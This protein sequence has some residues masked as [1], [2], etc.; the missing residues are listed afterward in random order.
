MRG[1]PP[2]VPVS[3]FKPP[4]NSCEISVDRMNFADQSE[5]A[6][7]AEKNTTRKDPSLRGWYTLTA[8]EVGAA[9]CSVQ[10]SP[11]AEN[12]Y[13]A[14]ILIPVSLSAADN[15][16]D[17]M[18]YARNLAYLADFEPW[19]DWRHEVPAGERKQSSTAPRDRSDLD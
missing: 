1:E 7:L 16:D 10:Y 18:E 19:G 12:S 13:H 2:R 8:A 6:A 15:R 3:K 9:K 11:T 4:D 17:L 14:D 5:L